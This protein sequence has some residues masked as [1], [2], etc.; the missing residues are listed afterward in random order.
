MLHVSASFM[1]ILHPHEHRAV[2]MRTVRA[3]VE[4]VVRMRSENRAGDADR[5]VTGVGRGEDECTL[6]QGE[7]SCTINT[8]EL[9]WTSAGITNNMD[10]LMGLAPE[11]IVS[12]HS[13]TIE[14]QCE[15][16]LRKHK[17]HYQGKAVLETHMGKKEAAQKSACSLFY[18]LTGNRRFGCAR[19]QSETPCAADTS[20]P[21]PCFSMRFKRNGSYTLNRLLTNTQQTFHK[22]H[23]NQG[24]LAVL[25]TNLT[26]SKDPDNQSLCS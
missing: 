8:Q 3:C 10:W 1:N 7:V 12:L 9:G 19:R 11:V 20:V 2:T 15:P 24:T 26:Y 4:K 13:T 23:L 16:A 14:T 21:K 17:H 25:A 18:P 22:P 5:L 6:P